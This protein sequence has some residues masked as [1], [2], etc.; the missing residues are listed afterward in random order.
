MTFLD[1]CRAELSEAWGLG[2]RFFVRTTIVVAVLLGAAC[3]Y[4]L[5][6]SE[7]VAGRDVPLILLV[8]PIY[9]LFHGASTALVLTP[10]RLIARLAGWATL[11]PV[12]ACVLGLVASCTLGADVI[13]D[14]GKDFVTVVEAQARS[15][16]RLPAARVGHPLMLLVLVPVILLHFLG[17]WAVW[18]AALAFVLITLLVAAIG[19]FGGLGLSLPPTLFLVASRLR[20]RAR[21][22]DE[23]DQASDEFNRQE[24]ASPCVPALTGRKSSP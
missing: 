3:L 9:G 7:N 5:A 12:F 2:A 18:K 15:M 11:L 16:G 10:L 6:T 19:A 22:R 21:A 17:S 13:A 23:N 1:H 14:A 8:L 24:S 20:D 4:G